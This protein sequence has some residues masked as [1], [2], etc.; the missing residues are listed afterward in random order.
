MKATGFGPSSMNSFNHYA[1]GA[2]LA[3]MHGTMAGIREDIASPGFK[4][5][6]LAP[7]PDK[8]VGHVSAQY[9]CAYG[10]I[11]SSWAYGENGTWTW[12]FTI[13]ANTTAKVTVPG[14]ETKEY[15]AGSYT[16]VR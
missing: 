13:P 8:R 16:V 3:W 11:R 14:C 12:S 4:H 2:V 7:I 1:Y 15:T 6:V 9:D 5:F 10:T